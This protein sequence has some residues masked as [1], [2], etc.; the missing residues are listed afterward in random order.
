MILLNDDPANPLNER[1]TFVEVTQ[2]IETTIP[3]TIDY[4]RCASDLDKIMAS[5]KTSEDELTEFDS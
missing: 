3:L 4:L 2:L 5:I 1:E